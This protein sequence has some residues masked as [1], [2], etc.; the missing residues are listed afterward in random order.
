MFIVV[1]MSLATIALGKDK[2]YLIYNDFVRQA[3]SGNIQSVTLDKFSSISGVMIDGETTNT[4]RSYADT[5]S[6]NDPLLTQFLKEHNIS[7]AM[8]DVS[9]PSHAMSMITGVMFLLAPL[10][11]LILM[12]VI[13]MKLN[14]V[15]ANQKDN[16]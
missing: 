12:I 9:E 2:Q 7:V 3:E 16:P 6:A 4:F 8:R 10:V 11:F 1:A 15:L 13:I 5:G 14:R